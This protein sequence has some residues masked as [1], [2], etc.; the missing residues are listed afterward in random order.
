MEMDTSTLIMVV[1]LSVIISTA[2]SVGMI[3]GVPTFRE[4]LRGPQGP[5]GPQGS[6]GVQ[7]EMGPPGPIGPQSLEGPTGPIGPK[8]ETGDP[9]ILEGEWT[10]IEGWKYNDWDDDEDT[11]YV[12]FS[13]DVWKI[14]FWINVNHEAWFYIAVYNGTYSLAETEELFPLYEHSYKGTYYTDTIIG[15][16]KGDYTV[17]VLGTFEEFHI[18]YFEFKTESQEKSYL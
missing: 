4:L 3:I 6:Q 18:H 11:E 1:I 5:E 10:H 13:Y 8:G 9:W 17:Y 12:T 2:T 14:D 15:F 7:G 16:G